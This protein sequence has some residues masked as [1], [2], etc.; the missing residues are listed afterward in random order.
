MLR[1]TNT[2][3]DVNKFHD[4]D[5]TSIDIS[6]NI[7]WDDLTGMRLEAG[8]V[9]EART[10]ELEYIKQKGVW[11]KI[12]RSVAHARG[13]KVIQTR[14]IDVNKGDDESPVYRSRLVGKE[15]NN[16]D[17][18]GIFAGTPPLEALRYLIHE[19]ATVEQRKDEHAKV[20]MINDVARAFFEARA[21]RTVCVELPLES[22]T[23]DD[24]RQ[25]MVGLLKMSLYGTRDAATNW[26]N[27]VAKQ[28]L[29]WGF[30][31]GKYNPC[32]Y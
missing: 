19:A 20:V 13:W 31:R 8:K 28:M 27:E 3:P 9:K 17:M 11:K 12:P 26:Q 21:M 22:L 15:F 1:L 10:K 30:K 23:E 7:A 5:E 24:R 6:S 25:D 29:R 4:K 32:L 14:W 16:G 18:D 2:L